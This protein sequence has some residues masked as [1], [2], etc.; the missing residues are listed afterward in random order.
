MIVR[1]S[2]R[3]TGVTLLE[4]LV[5]MAVFSVLVATVVPSVSGGRSDM[6]RVS[7]LNTLHEIIRLTTYYSIDD[8][9]T[10]I[11]PVHPKA[12]NFVFEG[13]AEY[14]GGPG[15]MNYV[16]W[17][18]EFDPRTRPLNTYI[19]ASYRGFRPEA[20]NRLYAPGLTANTQPGDFG[21]FREFLC[22]G[23]DLGW[24][25]WPGYNSPP[26]ETERPYF[27]AN[28]T[29]YR[30]NNL[31]YLQ[32]S[33]EF[34][35]GVYGKSITRIPD[36]SRTIAF[37]EARVFQTL[38]TNDTFGFIQPGV[39]DG[40]HNRKG[41]F[42]VAYCDGSVATRDFGSR[43]YY[44]QNSIYNGFDARGTWGRLD[45]LPFQIPDPALATGASDGVATLDSSA[46]TMSPQ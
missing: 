2:S 45:T 31:T 39:L 35:V 7:C 6:E 5:A 44:L 13:Y 20:N 29:S 18:E 36:P 41:Y 38:F 23:N 26:L 14:G 33:Q 32:G 34:I 42:N 46:M 4:M 16:G 10:I 43:S 37:H 22:A 27:K 3:R 40:Y 12:F 24:Q 21:R 9:N 8:P 19:Y 15:T 17:G 30:L 1:I 25:E 28:G 11:G